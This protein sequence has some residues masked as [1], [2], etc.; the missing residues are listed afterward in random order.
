MGFCGK[1]TS[2]GVV[3]SGGRKGF[4]WVVCGAELLLVT[5]TLW[6]P[7]TSVVPLPLVT[8]IVPPAT[9]MVTLPLVS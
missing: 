8:A 7:G 1:V 2:L 9:N 3:P 6:P 5:M 4:S